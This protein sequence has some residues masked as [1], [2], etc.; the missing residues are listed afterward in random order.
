M[1]QK[2]V[3]IKKESDRV[4]GG[5]TKKAE[6]HAKILDEALR[7]ND[8]FVDHN[9][10]KKEI[11]GELSNIVDD[12]AGECEQLEK[13]TKLPTQDVAPAATTSAPYAS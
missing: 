4:V 6:I 7:E 3:A 11:K 9:K 12:I 10:M 13:A 8:Y 5:P 2:N 1:K